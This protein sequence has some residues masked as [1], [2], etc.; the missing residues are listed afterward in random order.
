MKRILDIQ[1]SEIESWIH[2]LVRKRGE[3]FL[4][5]GPWIVGYEVMREAADKEGCM[6]F[7][8][9]TPE[10]IRQAADHVDEDSRVSFLEGVMVEINASVNANLKNL[11]EQ[12]KRN[13]DA[14]EAE[15]LVFF[16]GRCAVLLESICHIF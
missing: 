8:D 11:Y 1:D 16:P 3:S 5:G 4:N 14:I 10:D 12:W 9:S 6:R 7:G 15:A 2:G 13:P